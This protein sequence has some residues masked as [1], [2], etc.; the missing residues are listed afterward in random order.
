MALSIYMQAKHK[1]YETEFTKI[2]ENQLLADEGDFS[3]PKYFRSFLEMSRRGDNIENCTICT[4][5]DVDQK[6]VDAVQADATPE[7]LVFDE[8]VKTTGGKPT[9]FKLKDTTKL[10]DKLKGH[11]IA[12][13]LAEK[14][15]DCA[16]NNK[17]LNAEDEKFRNYHMALIEEK[18]IDLEKGMFHQDFVRQVQLSEGATELRAA[19]KSLK[20]KKP[21]DTWTFTHKAKNK[22]GQIAVEPKT[23]NYKL[24]IAVTDEE[25]TEF[26]NKFIFAANAPSEDELTGI[27]KKEVGEHLNLLDTDHFQSDYISNEMVDWF[28]RKDN[29]WLSADEGE[30]IFV[31]K[32]Q[33]KMD[34]LRATAVSIDYRNQLRR[35]L[36]FN[37]KAIDQMAAKLSGMLTSPAQKIV[38]LSTSSLKLTTVKVVTALGTDRLKEY[39]KEDSYLI[40]PFTRLQNENDKLKIKKLLHATKDSHYLLVIVCDKGEL[41]EQDQLKGL[42]N[43]I[44]DNEEKKGV[45]ISGSE[46][47]IKDA[48]SFSD[49][50][51]KSK[52][53]FLEK[54]VLFQGKDVRVRDLVPESELGDV[55]DLSSLTELIIEENIMIPSLSVDAIRFNKSLYIPRNLNFPLPLDEQFLDQ[56]IDEINKKRAQDKVHRDWLLNQLQILS[57][58]IIQ[59][60]DSTDP[61]VKNEIWEAMK[62]VVK[63]RNSLSVGSITEGQLIHGDNRDRKVITDYHRGGW[64][65]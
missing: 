49:L 36:E 52:D 14:L 9:C 32:V 60:K 28:K 55:I 54:R 47:E 20:T 46:G 7:M 44:I 21:W 40:F 16:T 17:P 51:D 30:K 62:T 18:V 61:K 29:I 24:P 3:V 1:M 31:R 8:F 56:T 42:E 59:W 26:F 22:F 50:S 41:V 2:K 6:L 5:A 25:I 27:L 11:S 65:R 10:R 58:G 53:Q 12:H 37:N 34:C 13:V 43:L 57:N 64:N 15:F 19:L 48:C 45:I 38:R 63:E 33:E 39:N 35:L 4:N 23:F